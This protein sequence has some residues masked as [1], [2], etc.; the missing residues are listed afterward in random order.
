MLLAAFELGAEYIDVEL[1]VWC[2]ITQVFTFLLQQENE[3][4]WEYVSH[5]LKQHV[6]SSILLHLQGPIGHHNE[7]LTYELQG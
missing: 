4:Y 6:S 3:L 2:L 1:K 7:S 5:M